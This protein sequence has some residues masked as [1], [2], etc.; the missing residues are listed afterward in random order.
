MTFYQSRR[1]LP[2]ETDGP[3]LHSVGLSMDLGAEF[4]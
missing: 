3:A 2:T 1:E 4:S